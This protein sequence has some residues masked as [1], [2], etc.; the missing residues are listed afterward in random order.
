MTHRRS[1]KNDQDTTTSQEVVPLPEGNWYLG[2]IFAR[3][4]DGPDAADGPEPGIA[5]WL[6]T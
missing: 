3:A 4:E 2:F 5:T 1:P 6:S